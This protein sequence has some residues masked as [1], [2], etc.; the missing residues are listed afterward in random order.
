MIFGTIGSGDC[1]NREIDRIEFLYKE[2]KVLC[3][4]METISVYKIAKKYNVPVIGIRVISDNEMLEEE[5]ERSIAKKSQKFSMNLCKM[6]IREG[7]I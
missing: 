6:L 7:K 2:Y 4:D 3:E 5:Y 1:W